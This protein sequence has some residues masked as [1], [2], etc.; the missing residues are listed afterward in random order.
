MLKVV[1]FREGPDAAVRSAKDMVETAVA[2]ISHELGPA[3]TQRFLH[4]VAELRNDAGALQDELKDFRRHVSA[5]GRNTW[6]AR[7]GAHDD[8]VLSVAIALWFATYRIGESNSQ[9]LSEFL[10][11]R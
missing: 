9:C 2:V 10:A 7:T 6:S 1:Y 11:E 4:V 3:E 5:A 8:L